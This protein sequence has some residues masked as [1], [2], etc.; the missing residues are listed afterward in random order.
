M[1]QFKFVKQRLLRWL[2]GLFWDRVVQY[3]VKIC[4]LIQKMC[5]PLSLFTAP[6]KIYCKET[7]HVYTPMFTIVHQP[8][9]DRISA[10]GPLYV[11]LKPLCLKQSRQGGFLLNSYWKSLFCWIKCLTFLQVDAALLLPDGVTIISPPL[12][13]N[14]YNVQYKY[15]HTNMYNKHCSVHFHKL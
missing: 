10:L 15:M 2:L 11:N 13:Y 8:R 9:M 6:T 3:F 4:G 5:P 12:R 14:V 1:S 7:L